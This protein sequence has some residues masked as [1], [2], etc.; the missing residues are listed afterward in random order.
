MGKA[1]SGYSHP[2]INEWRGA[3]VIPGPGEGGP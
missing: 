1:E 3:W 2:M